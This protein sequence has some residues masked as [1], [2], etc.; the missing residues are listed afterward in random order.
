MNHGRWII[1]CG[2]TG[3]HLYPGV[4]VAQELRKRGHLA[5]LLVSSKAIDGEILRAHPDLPARALP[6]MG[7]PGWKSPKLLPFAWSVVRTVRECQRIFRDF[8][9]NGVLAMGGFTGLVPLWLGKRQN[10]PIFLHEANAKPGKLTQLWARHV[11]RVFL[12]NDRCR[13]FLPKAKVTFTG[14]PIRE[15]LVRLDREQAARRLGLSAQ[16]QTLLIMGGSQG[17]VGINSLLTSCLPLWGDKREKWQWIH[18]CG[19]SDLERCQRAYAEYGLTHWVAPFSREMAVLYSLADLAVCRAGAATLAELAYYGIASVLIPY[20]FA[21]G[22]HQMENARSFA[23]V[24]AAHVFRQEELTPGLLDR[25]VRTM[26]EDPS[27][28]ERMRQAA[29]SLSVPGA[30]ANI[31]EELEKWIHR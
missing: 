5:M 6:A 28:L 14:N 1:A 11:D 29:A 2:G 9:P 26:L 16:R 17:A 7:W 8:A 24:G 18:L 10:L 4:A 22:D 19:F 12:G 27:G 25:V 15:G 23:E 20:P 13:T 31:A 30:A 21:S 3:G